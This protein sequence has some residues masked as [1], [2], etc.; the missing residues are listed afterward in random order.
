VQRNKNELRGVIEG[1]MASPYFPVEM[2]AVC[3]ASSFCDLDYGEINIQG[4]SVRTAPLNHPQACAAYRLDAD[5]GSFVFAT[6]T[7]PGSAVHDRALRE[8]ARGADVLVYDA[9]YSPE[10][11]LGEKKGWG[12]SSWFEGVRIAHECGVNRLVLTHHDPDSDDEYV[13]GL[14]ESARK[15]FPN[16]EGAC[17]GLEILLPQGEVIRDHEHSI[18]RRERRYRVELPVRVSWET[19]NGHPGQAEG[20]VLSVSKSGVYFV[21]PRGIPVKDQFKLEIV[22]PSEIAGHSQIL[23]QFD[24]QPVRTREVGRPLAGETTSLGIVARRVESPSTPTES[25]VV[26][27]G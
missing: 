13:D 15:L 25:E 8:L 27:T 11:L 14:V 26:L 6:D 5:G 20:L 16:T 18:P 7:E 23:A 10:K 19:G 1:Q 2:T 24:V 22:I 12:H 21:V 17:E 3:S 9:Q 4:A